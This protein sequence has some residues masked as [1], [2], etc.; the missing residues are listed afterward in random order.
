MTKRFRWHAVAVAGILCATPSLAGSVVPFP[1]VS[2][3]ASRDSGT[4]RPFMRAANDTEPLKPAH[5]RAVVGVGRVKRQQDLHQS[6]Q[7]RVL[8]RLPA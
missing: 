6:R 3:G 5:E 2:G 8:T 7:V 4:A 1:Q